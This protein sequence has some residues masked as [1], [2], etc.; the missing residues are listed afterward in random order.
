MPIQ[1]LKPRL[2]DH[3]ERA[4]SKVKRQK[5]RFWKEWLRRIFF[6]G[7]ILVV[8]GFV[9]LV[10]AFIIYS[11]ALPDPEK[12]LD[13]N[14]AQS[15]KI[16]DRTGENILY[17]LHGDEKRTLVKLEDIPDYMKWATISTEDKTFYEHHGFNLLAMFK[18]TIIDPLMGKRAR[19]G[20]TLTQQFVKNAILTNERK[21]SR[22]IKEFILSYKIEQ[23]FSKDEILQMYLNEIPYGSV[24]YGVQSASQTFFS[25]DVKEITLAEAAILASL[26][27]APTFYSPYG[28]NVDKLLAR[29]DYVLDLMAE[30]GYITSEQADEA[31]AQEIQFAKRNESI[32]APHFIM[33]VKEILSEQLG[34]EIVE[35]GG[36]KVITTLDLDKQ[37]IAEEAVATGV[38]ERGEK[39]DFY[40]AALLSLESK[41][42]QILAMVGSK[43]YFGES[44][45][46]GCVSGK[47]CKFEP[48]DNVTIRL[49][50]PGSSI[51]PM[52]YA[53]AFQKGFSPNTILYDVET[54]FKTDT[55]DYKPL[56][57]DLKERGP[58]TIR[59]S[60]AGSL[61]IPAVKAMYLAGIPNVLDLLELMGYS[62]FGD[63]SRFGLAVVLGGGEVK[64]VEHASSFGI[65]ANQGVYHPPVAILRVEDSRGNVLLEYEEKSRKVM[66]SN[67]ANMVSNVL[68]DNN[69]RAFVFGTQNPLN[70]GARPVAA[71]TGTTNNFHDAWTMGYTPSLVTGVWVGNNDNSEM[72]RGADGSIV[73]APIWNEYM[74]KVLDG[75]P[76]EYFT[77]PKIEPTGKEMLDGTI[78]EGQTV[79]IDKYSKKLATDMTPESFVEEKTFKVAHSILHYVYKDDPKGDIPEDPMS[80]DSAY[81]YW[82]A[83]VQEW[84]EESKDKEVEGQ[85]FVNEI[86]PTEYDD[87]HTEENRPSVM[88]LSPSSNAVISGSYLDVQVQLS[89]PRGIGRVEYYMDDKKLVAKN[90]YPYNLY[91]PLSSYFVRGYHKLKVIAYDD[92]DNSAETSIDINITVDI[93][94]PAINWKNPSGNAVYSMSNFPVNLTVHITDIFASEKIK[95]YETNNQTEQTK[96]FST[97]I[98]PE[99][100]DVTVDWPAPDSAGSYE[101][102]AE[103]IDPNGNSYR[104]QNL[105]ISVQ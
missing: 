51:K 92:V 69:A 6:G 43:D 73:A 94:P 66:D 93:P 44:E 40:N 47:N 102:F 97:V 20:S 5:G 33:Y 98:L 83:A 36:L 29:K 75:T 96:N 56:D 4:K 32:T 80:A 9:Y 3:F 45:P 28:N 22:K 59:Q 85:E 72:N 86:P 27:K 35:S 65:L 79:K 61:N 16:Y 78:P 87:V 52:V 21:I 67:I 17:D 2:K 84:V 95:F 63:R 74:R 48:N 81:Q 1:H 54:I 8:V 39:Y 34:D 99:S 89:A 55:K 76:V 37:K 30:N 90:N 57:Y 105:N 15:T 46:E 18:G 26:P 104:S 14:I 103:I 38:E 50:Q 12:I 13:R 58:V 7:L 24:S 91:F 68:S 88:I 64:M 71:K 49:R 77:E 11:R 42:G 53:A 23:T 82:E 62:S 19:G 70:L 60:L 31:S 10:G 41:T 100:N 101:I 25:K